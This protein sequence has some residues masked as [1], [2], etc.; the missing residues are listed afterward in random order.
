MY[1]T[2]V[3]ATIT[4]AVLRLWKEDCVAEFSIGHEHHK[5]QIHEINNVSS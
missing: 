5:P 1:G 3:L 2:L 4:R